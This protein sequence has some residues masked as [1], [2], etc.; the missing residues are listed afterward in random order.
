MRQVVERDTSLRVRA[1]RWPVSMAQRTVMTFSSP[2]L[3]DPAGLVAS[4]LILAVEEIV[5]AEAA[6]EV[7]QS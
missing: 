5:A 1:H 3:E 6:Q 2:W 7:A 4:I